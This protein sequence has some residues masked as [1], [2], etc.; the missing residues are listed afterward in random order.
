MLVVPSGHHGFGENVGAGGGRLGDESARV[1]G[2][3]DEGLHVAHAVAQMVAVT[4]D[5]AGVRFTFQDGD[6]Q[7]GVGGQFGGSGQ[8]G[9]SGADDGD[10]G[11]DNGGHQWLSCGVDAPALAGGVLVS[12]RPWESRRFCTSAPQ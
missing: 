4:G 8:S 5:S 12:V 11:G 3:G 9:G 6:L 2:P 7:C 10:V 1:G